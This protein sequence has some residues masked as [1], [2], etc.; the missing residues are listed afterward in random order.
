MSEFCL[1]ATWRRW[2]WTSCLSRLPEP[3][4]GW[5]LPIQS[6]TFIFP[7]WTL[8]NGPRNHAIGPWSQISPFMTSQRTN[9]KHIVVRDAF[10]CSCVLIVIATKWRICI[11]ME[12]LSESHFWTS[13]ILALSE[14]DVF[15]LN[16]EVIYCSWLVRDGFSA[17]DVSSN[18]PDGCAPTRCHLLI[19]AKLEWDT[20]AGCLSGENS[21]AMCFFKIFY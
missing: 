9:W 4:R 3:T 8:V 17:V 13:E 5:D 6:H 15:I 18:Y 11:K 21:R 12:N 19:A 1:E 10:F 2:C 7:S 20:D 16:T 14:T